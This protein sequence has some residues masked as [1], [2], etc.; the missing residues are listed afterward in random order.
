MLNSPSAC[1]DEN[2]WC[3]YIDKLVQN[4][5]CFE[6]QLGNHIRQYLVKSD[7]HDDSFNV[8]RRTTS[9]QPLFGYRFSKWMTFSKLADHMQKNI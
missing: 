4:G 3:E 5:Q 2:G 9:E 6:I 1:N 7:E 8:L